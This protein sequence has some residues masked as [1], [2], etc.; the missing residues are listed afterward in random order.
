MQFT[1]DRR[2]LA[3]A[4]TW[5][6][7]G[8]A[9][10]PT[11]PVLAG[12]LLTV[13]DGRLHVTGYDHDVLARASHPVR[14]HRDGAA[15]VSGRL[16][17]Q[18][19]KALPASEV[20]VTAT[21]P[22]VELTCGAARFLLPTMPAADY[23]AVPRAPE[24]AGTVTAGPF[25]A[26][27]ARVVPAAARDSAVPVLTGVRCRFDADAVTL[28]ATDRYRLAVARVPWRA[29]SG[30]A[31]GDVVVPAGSLDAAARAVDDPAREM[32]LRLPRETGGFGLTVS[33]RLMVCRVLDGRPPPVEPL[34]SA[35]Y[36]P[37][38][39]T[40]TDDLASAVRRVSLVAGGTSRITL[41]CRDGELAVSAG[42]GDAAGARESIPVRSTGGEGSMDFHSG[43]VMDGLRA[44]GSAV[45]RISVDPVGGRVCLTDAAD[46]TGFRYVLQPLR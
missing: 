30:R 29:G 14:R 6:G 24:V 16:L 36:L 40:R 8:V 23:P 38:V 32:E 31:P 39:D 44:V 46:A 2:E 11:V 19:V 20:V 21:G 3:A 18:I 17:G 13:S 37:L 43:Y 1:I 7:Q 28:F 22:L 41:A 35:E 25:A 45:T 15:L 9:T 33:E 5:A 10:H 26:A 27:V 12:V 42:G 34:L 4:M